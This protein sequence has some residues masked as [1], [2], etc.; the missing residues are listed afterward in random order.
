[1]RNEEA[2]K[3]RKLVLSLLTSTISKEHFRFERCLNLF[4]RV[5]ARLGTVFLQCTPY[6]ASRPFEP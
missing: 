6:F 5:E 2:K 3:R 1:V 4:G